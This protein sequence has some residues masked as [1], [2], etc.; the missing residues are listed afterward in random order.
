[1]VLVEC[2][3]LWPSKRPYKRCQQQYGGLVKKVKRTLLWS[4]FEMHQSY[5]L[6]LSLTHTHTHTHTH[7]HTPP[8]THTH[9]HAAGEKAEFP[10]AAYEAVG[11]TVVR[12][13]QVYAVA[14]I[15]TQIRP[16][17]LDQVPKLAKK[18]LV[19]MVQP[20]I[21]PQLFDE[22]NQQQTNVFALDCVPRMLSRGQTFDVLSSQANVRTVPVVQCSAWHCTYPLRSSSI[23]S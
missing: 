22:L 6:S 15:I 4:H 18:T 20:S 19:S 17:S 8:R 10:D 13:E 5:S 11:A 7:K 14:D 9:T 21:N 3:G 2:A 16:P 1:M 23:A 12:G